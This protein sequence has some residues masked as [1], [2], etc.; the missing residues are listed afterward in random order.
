MMR[1]GKKMQLWQQQSGL[2]RGLK[3]NEVGTESA[4]AMA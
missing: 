3:V 1:L 4:T 2:N